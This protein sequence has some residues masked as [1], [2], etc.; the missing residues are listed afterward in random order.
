[1]FDDKAMYD[2]ARQAKL[3]ELRRLMVD[4]E[5]EDMTG[6]VDAE[7]LE[8]ALAEATDGAEE[9]TEGLSMAEEGDE[10]AGAELEEEEDPLAVARRKF[11]KP[12]RKPERSPGTAIM[13]AMGSGKKPGMASGKKLEKGKV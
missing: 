7:K 4:L 2:D 1:M 5:L 13:I 8:Q 11:F 12:E 10:E 9:A 6:G 3:K